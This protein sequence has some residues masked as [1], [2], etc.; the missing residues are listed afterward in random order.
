VILQELDVLIGFAV[1]MSIASLLIMIATQAIASILAFRGRNLRDALVAVFLKITPGLKGNAKLLAERILKDPVYS[2]S[3]LSMND[4]RIPSSWKLSS[5]IRAEECLG[6]LKQIAGSTTDPLQEQ[7]QQLV[8]DIENSPLQQAAKATVNAITAATPAPGDAI[9]NAQHLEALVAANK[10]AVE[11]ELQRWKDAFSS[12]QDRAEQWFTMNSRWCTVALGFVTAFLLQLD[13][14]DLFSRISTDDSLR[15]GLVNLSTAVGKRAD[16]AMNA[17]SPGTV[18]LAVLNQMH[19]KDADLKGFPAAQE[20]DA[21]SYSTAVDWL[22]EEA[23]KLQTP[24]PTD[25]VSQLV[26]RFTDAVQQKSK[27]RLDAATQEFSTIAG[28]Y[29]QSKLQLLPDP[30]PS[31][32]AQF[33]GYSTTTGLRHFF[34]M[35]ATAMLLA[36]G[37]PFWF[38][39]LKSL[40]NLRSSVAESIDKEKDKSQ[41]GTG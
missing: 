27:E 39:L 35:F 3:S 31:D 12:A 34:G 22:K 16:E 37:A 21:Q 8:V 25:K 30:Y 14:F 41:A 19:E 2:D 13:T 23:N 17:V 24:L 40:T 33:C 20:S 28:L 6:V 7:A 4:T 1:V 15:N 32:F 36:L 11:L 38:N 18:Y 9:L 29:G 26:Q 5:A 10:S